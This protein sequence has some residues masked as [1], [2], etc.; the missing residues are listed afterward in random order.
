M[1]ELRDIIPNATTAELELVARYAALPDDPR[2]ELAFA[3]FAETGLPHRR[4]EAWRWTDFKAGLKT[5]EKPAGPD[6][7]DPFAKLSGAVFAFGDKA[8]SIPD[9]LPAGVKLHIR[10]E[11]Q[12]MGN[13]E[14]MPLGALTAALVGKAGGLNTLLIE[15]TEPVAEPLRFVFSGGGAEASFARVTILVREGAWLNLI[16]SHLG[17]A[18]FSSS[19]FRFDVKAG[20]KLSRTLYQAGGADEAHA[21]TTAVHLDAGAS[22]G[23]T[24]LAFGAKVSRLETRVTLQEDE[25]SVRLDAAYLAGK[26]K[27]V[28]ITS[29]VR[30]GARTCV[31]KQL[32]KG[33]V[34]DGGRGIF[35]GKFL[36][37][38]YVGQFTDADMQHHAL[39][40]EDGAEVFA[41]PE[42]EIY[43]DDVECAHGNTCGALDENA[44]FYMRQ[45]GLPETAARAL[46]TEA[47]VSEALEHADETAREIMLDAAR[48]WLA[49][50]A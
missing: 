38:R 3:S 44:L 22:Y 11:P 30:H 29:H 36:V 7:A 12:A 34:V 42:L 17:G 27:H 16:E 8:V 48:D 31:T 6:R 37:P 13:A 10:N 4:M 49:G 43:A 24:M 14:D 5:L 21:I 19:L 1:T 23:Q 32:T 20:A 35:Q 40:L 18:G 28:D 9:A 50:H 33:A 15:V 39:L 25:A 2:R 47:F 45:R 46:L 26:G 41:K